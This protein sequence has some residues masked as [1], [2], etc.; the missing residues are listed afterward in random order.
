MSYGQFAYT[1]Y[2]PSTACTLASSQVSR[3]PVMITIII[4][5]RG[6]AMIFPPDN[7]LYIDIQTFHANKY[8]PRILLLYQ[9]IH[10]INYLRFSHLA[11]LVMLV[12]YNQQ[13]TSI[14]HVGL[15]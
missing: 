11:L 12:L 15:S 10:N 6:V 13:F 4:P 2:S 8:T 14:V 5:G 1:T 7:R 3:T 9:P